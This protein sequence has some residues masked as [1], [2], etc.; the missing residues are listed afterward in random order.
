MLAR[1]ICKKIVWQIV[2][3]PFFP[4]GGFNFAM[5]SWPNHPSLP[6]NNLSHS[7]FLL[8]SFM[9]TNSLLNFNTIKNERHLY[10]LAHPYDKINAHHPPTEFGA[11]LPRSG[12]KFPQSFDGLHS[13]LAP[14]TYYLTYLLQY[15]S[16][17]LLLLDSFSC[18]LFSSYQTW[19]TMQIHKNI[20]LKH[21]LR[22]NF[23][24][25]KND[26]DHVHFKA[27]R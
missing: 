13:A 21:A 11:E 10:F 24:T 3:F 1:L 26:T 15:P 16:R 25:S 23:R 2:K 5:F 4:C 14:T 7:S 20:R 12:T 9:K 8:S 22:K 18:Y 17:S 27:M 6:S 19:S